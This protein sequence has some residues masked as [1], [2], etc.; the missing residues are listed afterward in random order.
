M[1]VLDNKPAGERIA[2]SLESIDETLK[3]ILHA[4]NELG[5]G[6]A[7]PPEGMGAIESQTME[8]KETIQRGFTEINQSII[9]YTNNIKYK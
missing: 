1:K 6:N 9:E 5:W 2:S 4:I 7:A 8:L 3:G